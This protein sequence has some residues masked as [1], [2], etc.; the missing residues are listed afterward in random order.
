MYLYRLGEGI[1]FF[2]VGL[3]RIYELSDIDRIRFFFRLIY[4]FSYYVIL[5]IVN[6]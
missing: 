2:G 6:N 1:N 4:I 3:I 5:L